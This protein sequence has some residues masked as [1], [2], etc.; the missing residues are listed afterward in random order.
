MRREGDG[1]KWEVSTSKGFYVNRKGHQAG[2]KGNI[3]K[4]QEDWKLTW[5]IRATEDTGTCVGKM[6]QNQSTGVS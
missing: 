3:S 5:S 1:D 4:T 6:R 2:M